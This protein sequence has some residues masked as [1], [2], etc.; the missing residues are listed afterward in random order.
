MTTTAAAA[1]RILVSTDGV[2][3]GQQ[4]VPGAA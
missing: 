2:E 3:D 1:P 4:V